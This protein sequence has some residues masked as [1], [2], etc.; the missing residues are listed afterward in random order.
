MMSLNIFLSFASKA[1]KNKRS[2]KYNIAAAGITRSKDSFLIK[3]TRTPI[4]AHAINGLTAIS[5]S[6]S[7]WKFFLTKYSNNRNINICDITVA[8]AAPWMPYGGIRIEFKAI[9]TSTAIPTLRVRR[10]SLFIAASVHP[11]ELHTNLNGKYRIK[12]RR[13]TAACSNPEP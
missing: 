11:V 7:P 12:T 8:I 1:F 3:K 2:A 13:A 10:G 6:G 5:R 9:F 4:I